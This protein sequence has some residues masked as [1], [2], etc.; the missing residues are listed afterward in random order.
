[1][2]RSSAVDLSEG[3]DIP[4]G[5]VNLTISKPHYRSMVSSLYYWVFIKSCG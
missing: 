2:L 1:V 5:T 3:E 4:E